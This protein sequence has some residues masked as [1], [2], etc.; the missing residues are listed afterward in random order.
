MERRKLLKALAVLSATGYV[1]SSNAGFGDLLKSKPSSGGSWKSVSAAFGEAK[2]NFISELVVQTNVSADI[3]SALDLQSEAEVMRAEAKAIEKEGDS[4]GSGD[5][6]AISEK[7][8]STQQ[9]ISKK[10]STADALSDSQKAELGTA[11]AQYVPSLIRGVTTGKAL[12]DIISDASGLGTPGFSDG[13]AALSAAKDIPT[14]APAMV[15]FLINSVSTGKD[16]VTTM[17]S[18]GVATPEINTSDFEGFV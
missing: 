4:L 1:S 17:S 13:V 15:N 16:L 18:K 6:G 7:S 12:K 14:L 10:L 9:L 11:A 5:I 3:A 8:K 2:K